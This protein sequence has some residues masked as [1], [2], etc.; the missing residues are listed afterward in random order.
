M[1][2]SWTILRLIDWTKGYLDKKGIATA[3]LDGELLLAHI[4]GTDRTHL[5][6]NFDQPLTEKEMAD[7]KA[8]LQRRA[9]HEPLQYITGEQEF[10][11]MSFRVSP[12][13]LIPRPETELLVEEGADAL[14]RDFPGE[15]LKILDIGTGSGALAAALASELKEAVV[16]GVDISKDAIGI[17]QKNMEKNGLSDVV[18]IIEGDLFGPVAG[19]RFHLIVSNPPYIPKSELAALQP[20]V[21]DFEPLSALDGGEDGLDYYRQ[22]IPAAPEFL[23]PGGWLMFEHGAG[24][25]ADIVGLFE[26][27]GCFEEITS[28]NDYAGLDRLVKGRL[29]MLKKPA[30]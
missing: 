14:G 6:M 9:K 30:P 16:T 11:S 25:S 27:T 23:V 4:L 21:K 5:Y 17:A 29:K 20:E 8:L 7:F 22:I 2:E 3:R 12:S 18:T 15:H 10:W 13:V 24:Q 19:A 26:K 1:E 28:V